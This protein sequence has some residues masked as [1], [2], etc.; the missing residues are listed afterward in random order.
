MGP[1]ISAGIDIAPVHCP[2][3]RL[4]LLRSGVPGVW[5]LQAHVT[6]RT[7]QDLFWRRLREITRIWCNFDID[8]SYSSGVMGGREMISQAMIGMATELREEAA[9]ARYL[10]ATFQDD[11]AV[12]DLLAYAVALEIDVARLE[13]TRIAVT[14]H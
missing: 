10:A 14:Y 6:K 13:Q 3:L 8:P 5:R 1:M 9:E 2:T 11:A 7:R 4:S 12:C